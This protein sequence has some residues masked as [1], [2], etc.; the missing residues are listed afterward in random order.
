[1][2]TTTYRLDA[3]AEVELAPERRELR[4][5]GQSQARGSAPWRARKVAELGDVLALEQIAPKG[6][7]R[8]LDFDL[9]Q[10]LRLRV[11]MKVPVPTRPDPNGDLVIVPKAVLAITYPEESMYKALPGWRFCHVESP[12]GATWHAN[13]LPFPPQSLCLGVV[14][15]PGVRV[16]EIILGAY[17]ALTMQ[18]IQVDELD[19]GGV[20]NRDAGVWWSTKLERTPL[21]KVPFLGTEDLAS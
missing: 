12:F 11:E 2:T 17:A 18:S 7:L 21:S 1:M 4:A 3:L 20:L 16:K 5:R 10:T 15:A 9:A 6:R 14:I 8:I 19:P 13:I